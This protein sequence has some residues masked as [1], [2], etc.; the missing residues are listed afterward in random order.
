ME[1]CRFKIATSHTWRWD[2]P[3]D[4]PEPPASTTNDHQQEGT[5]VQSFGGTRL[6]LRAIILAINSGSLWPTETNRLDGRMEN[7]QVGA[8]ATYLLDTSGRT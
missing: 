1:P 4:L 8:T 6:C 7:N 2:L 3:A 5:D